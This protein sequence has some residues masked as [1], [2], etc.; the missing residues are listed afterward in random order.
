MKHKTYI[1][2]KSILRVDINSSISYENVSIY[3]VGDPSAIK[4][5]FSLI[6]SLSLSLSRSFRET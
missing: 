2:I 6:L 5:V 4:S 1:R 3:L